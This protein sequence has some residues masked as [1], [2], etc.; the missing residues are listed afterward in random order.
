MAESFAPR[1]SEPVFARLAIIGIGLI[2]SSIARA[3]KELNLAGTIVLADR[4]EAAARRALLR[5]LDG[6]A[7][8][9]APFA[10]APAQPPSLR[11]DWARPWKAK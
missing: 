5:L 9:W 2:G 1:R 8:R 6:R 4:D 3:A 7:W 10:H 11:Q